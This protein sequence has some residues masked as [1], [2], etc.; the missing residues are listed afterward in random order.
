VESRAIVEAS[1]LRRRCWFGKQFLL[2]L[3]NERDAGRAAM[4]LM[5]IN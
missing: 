5:M 1:S 3:S 4:A 2:A